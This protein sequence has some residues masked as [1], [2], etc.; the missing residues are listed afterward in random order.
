MRRKR[1]LKVTFTFGKHDDKNRFVHVEKT[2]PQLPCGCNQS[3][4]TGYDEADL[5]KMNAFNFLND[6]KKLR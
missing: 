3:V 2:L 6:L 5:K 1:A 4:G